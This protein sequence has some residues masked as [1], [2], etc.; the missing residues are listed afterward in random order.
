MLAGNCTTFGKDGGCLELE[1]E[2]D[3]D[4]EW[5]VLEAASSSFWGTLRIIAL[6]ELLTSFITTSNILHIS[7]KP[8]G[9]LKKEAQAF[10]NVLTAGR[11]KTSS[12]MHLAIPV[13]AEAQSTPVE[14]KKSGIQTSG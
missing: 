12:R 8:T 2:E 13:S 4:N 10:R 9:F 1:D 3:F 11:C 6:L 5:Y 14:A 7:F